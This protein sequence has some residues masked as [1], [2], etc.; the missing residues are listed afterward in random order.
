MDLPAELK[1]QVPSLIDEFEAELRSIAGWWMEHARDRENGGFVGRVDADDRPEPSANKG[2]IL[3]ARI[4]WFFSELARISG[5]SR[6]R[7]AARTA[8]EYLLEYFWDDEHGGVYWEL[9]CRGTVVDP[10]KH[11]YAQSFALYG[12]C[13]YYRLTGEP[14]ALARAAGLYKL[15][16]THGHD[17]D[18]GGYFE[19]F[20]REWGKLDDVRLSDKD[21]NFPKTMNTHLHILEAFTALHKVNPGEDT[22]FSLRRLLG[23]FTRYFIDPERFHLRVFM[24][25]NWR[26]R[27]TIISY[28]HDVECSWLMWEAVQAL[29]DKKLESTFKPL[30]LSM[31]RACLEQGGGGY[32]ELIDGHDFESDR[33]LE[34]RLWWVQAEAMVGFLN[35]WQLSGDG[36]YYDAFERV[37]AFVKRYQ[38][39]NRNGEWHWFSTLD[40]EHGRRMYKA[41]LWKA[42]YHNGRAMMEVCERLRAIGRAPE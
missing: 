3:N 8:C 12:L 37:W 19:A 21:P 39:D 14:G 25:D 5:D 26:D 35:A 31:A 1:I 20:S 40:P 28:G 2:I 30:V 42:P 10:R 32:G 16:E 6:H 7:G 33:P 11:N 15:I 29:A 9:D 22:A 17:H 23:Y 38:R 18:R 24:D 27:S 34:A 4:L 41:G 36:R 13:A